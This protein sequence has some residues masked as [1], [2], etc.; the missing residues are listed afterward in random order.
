[1]IPYR[2]Y[3]LRAATLRQIRCNS[4]ADGETAQNLCAES[5]DERRL[6]ENIQIVMP[7]KFFG[8][9]FFGGAYEPRILYA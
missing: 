6:S 9:L 7:R 2:Q 8:A 4:E 5:P 3:S 1:M